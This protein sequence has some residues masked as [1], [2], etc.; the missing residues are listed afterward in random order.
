MY[1]I[2]LGIL[3]SYRIY[4]V[5]TIAIF[6]N[7]NNNAMWPIT[8]SDMPH[9]LLPRFWLVM[10]RIAY[11]CWHLTVHDGRENRHCVLFYD[12]MI[13]GRGRTIDN[14]IYNNL[15]IRPPINQPYKIRIVL[16]IA[17]AISIYS[18]LD[19]TNVYPS[20]GVRTAPPVLVRMMRS[21]HGADF[22]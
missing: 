2:Y 20:I 7:I 4:H 19:L 1:L 21:H 6:K 10:V 12:V 9:D 14:R 3:A 17:D 5:N 16:T 11:R 13:S 15:D 18:T 8:S 22:N